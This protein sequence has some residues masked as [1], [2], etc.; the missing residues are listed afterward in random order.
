M[1]RDF[2]GLYSLRASVRFRPKAD[3]RGTGV[4]VPFGFVEISAILDF[5]GME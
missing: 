2:R 3:M 5:R 1:L 4:T